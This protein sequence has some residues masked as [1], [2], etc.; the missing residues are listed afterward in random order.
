MASRYVITVRPDASV[1]P[2]SI[3]LC[4]LVR[5]TNLS[6]VAGESG[7]VQEKDWVFNGALPRCCVGRIS[8]SFFCLVSIPMSD[9]QAGRQR[10]FS[11]R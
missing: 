9:E 6:G 5:A 1:I 8:E 10:F 11:A 2:T 7:M 3:L 4:L